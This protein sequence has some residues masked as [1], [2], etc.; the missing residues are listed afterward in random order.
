LMQVSHACDC[1]DWRLWIWEFLTFIEGTWR[2][3]RASL[4]LVFLPAQPIILDCELV[5]GRFLS[6]VGQ[7]SRWVDHFK[8]QGNAQSL[9]VHRFQNGL[10]FLMLKG[11]SKWSSL[12][13]I[14]GLW[15]RLQFPKRVVDTRLVSQL[16]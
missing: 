1:L 10:V 16:T 14:L 13:F 7:P 15:G 2:R 3:K 8:S 4:I 12:R 5:I 6:D 9:W 11:I